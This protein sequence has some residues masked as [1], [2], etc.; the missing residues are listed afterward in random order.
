MSNVW[1]GHTCDLLQTKLV[2]VPL[3]SF[4]FIAV[5]HKV[6]F[7]LR[8]HILCNVLKKLKSWD[9]VQMFSSMKYKILALVDRWTSLVPTQLDFFFFSG[10]IRPRGSKT[11]FAC[12]LF[13]LTNYN[14]AI[15]DYSYS[16]CKLYLVRSSLERHVT[17]V[18]LSV[19]E[20]F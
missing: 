11:Y 4:C 9:W 16:R 2:W 12:D 1:F 5:N 14:W 3:I 17:T 10:Q 6:K 18:S 19:Q 15:R 7:W 20:V 8:I 13:M